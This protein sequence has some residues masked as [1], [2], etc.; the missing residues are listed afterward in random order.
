LNNLKQKRKLLLVT[1]QLD[2]NDLR[3]LALTNKQYFQMIAG[4]LNKLQRHLNH[5]FILNFP[6]YFVAPFPEKNIWHWSI[7]TFIVGILELSGTM[8]ILNISQNLIK[9]FTELMIS[10][11]E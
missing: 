6:I 1:H 2:A 4:D 11:F 10:R 7:F 3:S 9:H 8:S 5:E